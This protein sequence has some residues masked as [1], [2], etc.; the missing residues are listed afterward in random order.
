MKT[1]HYLFGIVVSFLLAGVLAFLGIVAVTTNNLGWGAAAL[2]IYALMF[3]GPLAIVL[4]V[5]WIAYLVRD[6]GKIPGRV[7][8]LLFLPTLVAVLI[9]PVDDSIQK[10]QNDSFRKAQPAITETHVNLSGHDIGLDVREASSSSGGGSQFL[11][12]ASAQNAQ[13]SN[14]RRYP[15]PEALAD[16]EFPYDAGRIKEDATRYR[17]YQHDGSP[18]ESVPLQRLPYPDIG[19]LAPAYSYGE[20]ALL[21]HQ[22]FHYADH[23]ELAPS[24]ARFA[25][26][27]EETMAKARIS[28]LTIFSL[29]NYTS[30]AIV[31]LE[32]NGQTQDLGHYPARSLAGLPCDP[33]RGGSPALVDLQQPLRVRWQTLEAPQQWREARAV[34]PDFSKAGQA[35]AGKGLA[36]VRLYFLPDETVAAE[37]FQEIRLRGGDLA[38]RATGV[39]APA[40]SHSVCGGAYGNFN[41]QT[42]TLLAE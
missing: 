40:K 21:V 13:F 8:A 5:T 32:I 2:L 25:G 20:A 26:T 33:P 16:G 37:R 6:R 30:Q 31:R 15:R 34:V 41:P 19:K 12:P 4:V 38:I 9:V 17:Y 18:A 10:S 42:V 14:F 27:T 28:G 1:R 36:R 7:H 23:V 24:L 39:P 35:D 29:E 22:Y 11:R 3:G